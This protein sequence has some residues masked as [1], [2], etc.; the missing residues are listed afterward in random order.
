MS[1]VVRRYLGRSRLAQTLVEDLMV[2][3]RTAMLAR[4]AEELARECIDLARLSQDTWSYVLDLL[5]ADL[6]VDDIDEI[7]RSMKIAS[8]T[9]LQVFEHAKQLMAIRRASR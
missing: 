9:T 4:D 2:E 6:Q 8:A 7:G 5:F 1:M 3:Q